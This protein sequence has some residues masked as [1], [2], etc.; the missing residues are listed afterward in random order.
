MEAFTSPPE[1]GADLQEVE[2]LVFIG[3][4]ACI[5]PR[6]SS[7]HA[8]RRGHL[9]TFIQLRITASIEAHRR[10]Q[11]AVGE[12]ETEE[13]SVSEGTSRDEAI[14]LADMARVL[15][16]VLVLVRPE[17]VDVAVWRV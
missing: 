1:D 12:I 13:L 2:I 15:E 14:P 10:A 16:L 17:R 11:H 6:A 8:A 5:G 3:K 4:R 9:I 7:D